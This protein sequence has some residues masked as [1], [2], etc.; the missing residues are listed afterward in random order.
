MAL[1]SSDKTYIRISQAGACPRR[2]Q[3]EAWGVEGLPP[4]EGSER[5]FAE[6]NLHEPSILE[7]AAQNLP[8]GPYTL[9]DQQK[10][11]VFKDEDCVI[12]V[13]H[14]DAIGT[15]SAGAKV[16]LE[17]KCLSNRGFQELREKGV[18]EAHPQYWTQVQLYLAATGLEKAYLVARNKET[19]RNRMWD[20]YYESI[21]L[22]NE[23]YF[24]NETCRLKELAGM[25]EHRLDI[26]PPYNPQDNWQCRP[27]WCPYTY[28]CHPDYRKAKTEVTD[29]SDLIATVEMLQEL[30]DEIK[31]LEAFRD[32]VKTKLIQ[33]AEAGPVQAGRWLVKVI[34]RRSERFDTKLARKELPADVLSKLLKVSTYRVLDVKEVE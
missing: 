13:G 7:W 30:N 14:I 21:L 8:A 9:S 29:R 19:P 12:A 4:W 2:I 3:L 22:E 32:E 10:E 26:D 15:N 31:A 24:W 23:R 16:L 18:Q 5:A 11:V 27:P 6:G 1:A 34:E 28:H 20:M 33:E 17:A 25:I